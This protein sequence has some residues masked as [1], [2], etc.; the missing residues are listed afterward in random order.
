MKVFI[1]WSKEPSRS[2][3]REL[4]SWLGG[5]VQAVEPWMSD[6]GV[7][8][9][10]RWRDLI[11]A[12]LDQTEFGI[13]CLTRANQHEPWLMF[14][15]GAIA[16][17][18]GESRIIPLY[19]D[20]EP[21]DVTGPLSDWQGR[22]VDRDGLWRIVQD[23]NAA[24]PKPVA[25][26]S[27]VKLFGRMWPEFETA[28]SAAKTAD[29]E[30]RSPVRSTE[31]MLEELVER[32]RRL[33]NYQRQSSDDRTSEPPHLPRVMPR[34]PPPEP[35]STQSAE[36]D[37]DGSFVSPYHSPLMWEQIEPYQ[38]V[39]HNL[40]RPA[41]SSG[42]GGF[43]RRYPEAITPPAAESPSHPA[44]SPPPMGPPVRREPPRGKAGAHAADSAPDH[45]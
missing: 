18:L 44:T 34:L 6:H 40:T 29:P 33:E 39:A 3:A 37:T 27:L 30:L 26:D 5:L 20:L 24:I 25:K 22:R 31:D 11:A 21:T 2:V 23:I 1:S 16:K 14:E 9:G 19:I 36:V 35:P 13:I 28:I 32:V 7:T 41:S 42:G 12:E 10:Q 17:H 38:S 15:A 8:S 43:A 4:A 45:G